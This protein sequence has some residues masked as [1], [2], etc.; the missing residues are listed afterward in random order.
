MIFREFAK[1]GS[2]IKL[3]FQTAFVARAA[4]EKWCVLDTP[5]PT[6]RGYHRRHQAPHNRIFA[7]ERHPPFRGHPG[8]VV[9]DWFVATHPN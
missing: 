3:P 7:M 8:L 2:Y 6:S 5:S 9:E 1:T 4:R